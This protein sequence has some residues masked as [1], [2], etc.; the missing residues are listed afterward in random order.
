MTNL[1]SLYESPEL[2]SPLVK[3]E[4]GS[5]EWTKTTR[6]V[7]QNFHELCRPGFV[8]H[9]QDQLRLLCIGFVGGP[10]LSSSVL[11][12]LMIKSPHV[13]QEFPVIIVL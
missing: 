7:V 11:P 8:V 6:R 13:Y 10:I 5:S 9:C 2:L 12:S 3:I 4:V 1:I